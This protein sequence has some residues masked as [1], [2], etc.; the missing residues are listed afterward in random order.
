MSKKKIIIAVVLVLALVAAACGGWYYYD[1]TYI[2]IN[3][4][5]YRR[6]ITTLN[7][8]TAAE[9]ELAK[10]PELT[11]LQQLD[12]QN[13]GLTDA[14]YESLKAAL[15][16][17]EILWSPEFQGT[18]CD[19]NTQSVTV[20]SLTEEDIA[21]LD[22]LT[23]LQTVDATGCYDYAQLAALKEHRPEVQVNY[24]VNLSGEDF[25]WDS[26]DITIASPDVAELAE[27]LQ[28]LPNLTSLT[29]TAP[30]AEDTD[31]LLDLCAAYPNVAISWDFTLYGVT[32]NSLATEVDLSN[33]PIDDLNL[34]ERTTSRMPQIQKV[35]M[36][37]C[38]IDNETM[39]ALNRRYEDIM[40][41]W[42]VDISPWHRLRTDVDQFIPVKQGYWLDDSQLYNLRYCTEIVGLDLGHHLMTNI[43]FV[44]YMPHLRYLIVADTRI[45]DI[46][47]VANLKEL[48]FFEMFG[49]DVTDYTPLL[50]LTA[51][52]DLNIS[53]TRGD[54]NIIAQMTWLKRLWWR[55]FPGMRCTEEEQAMLAE[56]LPG[57]PMRFD[58][59]SSTGDGWREGYLYFEMRDFFGMYY[60]T[61]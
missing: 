57:V 51:L 34:V 14:Q 61:D 5:T 16:G 37:D 50:G 60:M 22:Y 29:I 10:L 52:E 26:T 45:S 11:Q 30:A 44:Q 23:Q 15:P 53:Y 8:P 27:K 32:I 58:A 3:G 42:T 54:P 2:Q 35:I 56:A 38:G 21:A 9:E 46:S 24:N 17:C 12:L 19:M 18:Y 31:A 49:T 48:V 1:T 25:A 59:S 43:D 40:Y 20:T 39:D 36:S 47:P 6:D 7:L 4:E 33:I 41:V 28:Y 13:T 55:D